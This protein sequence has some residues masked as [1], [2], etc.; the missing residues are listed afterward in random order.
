MVYYRRTIVVICLVFGVIGCQNEY[1]SSYYFNKQK[2]YIQGSVEEQLYLD[3]ALKL[4]S[5]HVEALVEKSVAFNKRGQYATGMH[6]LNKGVALDPIEHLGYR[7]FIKLYM[8]RD[9][10]GAVQDFL[11][12]DSLTPEYRDAPWGEDIYKVIGLAYMGMNDFEKALVSINRSIEE[13]TK[14]EGEDWIESRTFMYQGICLMKRQ[15]MDLALL[16]FDKQIQYCKECPSGYYYKA[17]VLIEVG[18]DKIEEMEYL[19]EKA[20]SLAQKGLIESSPYFELPF[21]IYL[22]DINELIKEFKHKRVN[23]FFKY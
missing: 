3:K 13:I 6:Y 19:L 14:D 10:D 2:Q 12:L 11:R 5:L 7:G 9:Y 4:D 8:L 21:Q 18:S 1:S 22:S 16:S 20:N 15:E 17:K 23:K